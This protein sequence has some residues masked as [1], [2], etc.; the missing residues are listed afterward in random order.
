MHPGVKATSDVGD[1]AIDGFFQLASGHPIAALR[2]ASTMS[3][4]NPPADRRGNG[5]VLDRKPG[6]AIG[7]VCDDLGHSLLLLITALESLLLITAL[8]HCS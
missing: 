4:G 6:N 3:I 2:R 8:G 7:G 5:H 1:V